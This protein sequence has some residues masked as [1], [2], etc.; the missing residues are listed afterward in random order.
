MTAQL[1]PE[2]PIAEFCTTGL[3]VNLTCENIAS[4]DNTRSL[5]SE[6]GAASECILWRRIFFSSRE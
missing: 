2:T 4:F 5:A 3:W 1:N 6:D